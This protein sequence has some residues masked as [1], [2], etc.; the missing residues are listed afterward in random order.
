MVK[1]A[2]KNLR[3]MKERVGNKRETSKMALYNTIVCPLSEFAM[4]LWPPISAMLQYKRCKQR[5]RVTRDV[6]KCSLEE[7]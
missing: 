1:N 6:E 5:M 4:Q 7:K 2:N 3:T